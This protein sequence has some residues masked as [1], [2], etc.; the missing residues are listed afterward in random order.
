MAEALP[1]A[2]AVLAAGKSRRFGRADKLSAD[3]R[4]KP[5]GLHAAETLSALNV[6]D[7]WVIARDANPACDHGWRQAG[8]DVI[9]NPRAE[10]GMGTSVA[11]AAMHAQQAGSRALVICLADMPLVPQSHFS[12][13]CEAVIEAGRAAIVVSSSRTSRT[14]PAGFGSNHFGKLA[15]LSGDS[16]ARDLLA[17]GRAIRCDPDW[18]VDIDDVETLNRLNARDHLD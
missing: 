5:L 16:G 8:F 4:G 17:A 12:A 3:F 7:K 1:I 15:R 6:M 2:V 9:A 10:E 11:L 13:L 18:L 14:P